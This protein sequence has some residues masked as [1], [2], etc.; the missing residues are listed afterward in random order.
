MNLARLERYARFGAARPFTGRICTVTYGKHVPRSV[1]GTV[2]GPSRH[3]S[4][5]NSTGDLIL[6]ENTRERALIS[7]ALAQITNIEVIE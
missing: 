5:G 2:L 7:V 3:F 4:N 1:T 6:R